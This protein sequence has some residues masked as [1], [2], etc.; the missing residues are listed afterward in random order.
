[1]AINYGFSKV[2]LN[3]TNKEENALLSTMKIAAGNQS[4][5]HDLAPRL[6]FSLLLK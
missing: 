1:M 2:I 5:V 4:Q 6:V 3:N